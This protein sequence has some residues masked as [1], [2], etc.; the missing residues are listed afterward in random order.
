MAS[1]NTPGYSGPRQT[2]D[3]RR[4]VAREKAR[5]LREQQEKRA[6]RN[7]ILTIVGIVVALLLIVLAVWKIVSSDNGGSAKELGDYQGEARP[8]A[9]TNVTDDHGIL[10]DAKGG[11]TT[12]ETGASVVGIWSDFMCIGCQNF[13]GT[14][15]PLMEQYNSAGDVQMKLYAVDSLGWK[16][17]TQGGAALYYVAEYAPEYTWAFNQALMEQGL[18]IHNGQAEEATAAEIADIAKTIGVPDDVVNDLPASIVTEEWQQLVKDALEKFRENGY[19]ATPTITV[20]GVA[21]EEWAND[22]ATIIPQIFEE[23]AA[24]SAK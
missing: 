23:A 6:K 1:K 21:N 8:V 20:N 7:K 22:P 4:A 11:A 9:T 14:Y 24:T 16:Y 18:A 15:H 2:K 10:L 5:A 19:R 17:S 13:D 3:E 12:E